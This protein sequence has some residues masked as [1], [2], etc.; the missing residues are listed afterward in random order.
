MLTRR[1]A[2]AAT[3]LLPAILTACA[4]PEDMA[5][6]EV[7]LHDV[8]F[9]QAGLLQQDVE[10]LLT[11]NNP[12]PNS[13]TLTG[14]RMSLDLNGNPLARGTSDETVT[15]PRLSSKTVP[16]RASVGSLDLARQILSLG[17]RRT[18]DYLLK[19]D[20]FVGRFEDKPLPFESTGSL[21]LLSGGGTPTL[22][23]PQ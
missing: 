4:T 2:I 20:A 13:M 22:R 11:V 17:Q 21:R 7:S 19:G 18:V 16:V 9:I 1:A 15:I 5:P 10:L 8:R 23:A 3:A 12:N 14:M 6:P